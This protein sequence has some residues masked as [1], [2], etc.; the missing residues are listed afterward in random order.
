MNKQIDTQLV[1][2]AKN[3]QYVKISIRLLRL[4][5]VTATS[6]F[7][8]KVKAISVECNNKQQS[9]WTRKEL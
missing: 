4:T 5:P 9:V 7:G 3:R 8:S 1:N 6:S 2:D